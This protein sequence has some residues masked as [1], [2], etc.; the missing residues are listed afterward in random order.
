MSQRWSSERSA[1]ICAYAGTDAEVAMA[2]RSTRSPVARR[3]RPRLAVALDDARDLVCDVI[4]GVSEPL[5]ERPEVSSQFVGVG[6]ADGWDIMLLAQQHQRRL[7]GRAMRARVDI[8]HE[9]L[10]RLLQRP[11]VRILLAQV[12]IGQHQI[13]LR[14][15]D[16]GLAA[17]L[18]S[19]DQRAHTS[20]SSA[21]NSAR[22][23]RS[24]R[25]A[26]RSR[27]HAQPSPSSRWNCGDR[28]VG[29]QW[30]C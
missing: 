2:T 25:C 7:A 6:R 10:T 24:S 26:P 16:R 23:Q 13:S 9:L 15:L 1:L 27:T 8:G 28:V 4:R 19:A 22:P 11:P 3:G 20:R 18:C 14:H 17:A 29:W 21:R 5:I 12:V 30:R